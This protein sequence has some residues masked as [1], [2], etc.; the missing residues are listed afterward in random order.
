MGLD[1]RIVPLV[2][3]VHHLLDLAQVPRLGLVE[4]LGRLGL[5]RVRVRVRIRVR[6]GTRGCQVRLRRR[7]RR[8]LCAAP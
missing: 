6:A 1:H 3:L 8:R 7:L 4:L 2:V 5:G